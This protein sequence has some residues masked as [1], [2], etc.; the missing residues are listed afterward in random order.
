M[1]NSQGA[2]VLWQL[3]APLLLAMPRTLAAVSIAPLFPSALFPTLLR[4]TVAISLALGLYPHLA[5]RMPD[6]L[7]AM[8]W[9]VLIAKEI[10]IGALIGIAVAI[11]VWVFESV[12]SII[13]VQVGY[14]NASLFDP[15][16][17]HHAGPV[18]GLMS[19][20]AI[21]LFVLGGGLQVLTSLLYESFQLWPVGSYYPTIGQ[22][23]ADFAIDTMGSIAQ[24]FVRLVAPVLLL[25]VMID[26]GFGLVGRVVPQLNV[27][28]FTMPI[29]GAV[30]ALMIALYVAHLADF[31]GAQI[32][33]LAHWL[34]RL[35]GTLVAQ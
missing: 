22:W 18:S 13:D 10:F 23:T 6:A 30:A 5:G 9:L 8:G 17:G 12:G 7:G 35:V 2:Q 29:K 4:N 14:G 34:E 21:V 26:L 33:D 31:V 19:R 20:L 32:E 11:L 28:Y 16:G 27:F 25:L 15:F 3:I 24:L 1:N